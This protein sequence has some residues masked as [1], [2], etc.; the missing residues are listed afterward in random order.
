MRVAVR[1]SEATSDMRTCAV[2]VTE[3]SAELFRSTLRV[4]RVVGIVISV[5]VVVG[6]GGVIVLVVI[7]STRQ[8][9]GYPGAAAAD[10]RS[11][12]SYGYPGNGYP[13]N[14]YPGNGY[15][16]PAGGYPGVAKVPSDVSYA[17]GYS[18]Q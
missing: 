17:S 5:V 4:I 6:I 1:V 2:N 13:G 15:P 9:R 7:R 18:Q 12:V 16:P 10:G 11:V 3:V 14:G 8:S